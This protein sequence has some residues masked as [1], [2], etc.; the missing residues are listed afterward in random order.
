MR[1]PKLVGILKLQ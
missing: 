1:T